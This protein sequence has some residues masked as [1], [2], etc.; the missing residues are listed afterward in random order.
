MT[1]SIEKTKKAVVLINVG[2]PDAPTV[3]AVRRYLAEFLWDE[4][5]IDLPKVFR[6]MLLH[7]IILPFRPK[8]SAQA[9][10]KIWKENGSP[11]LLHSRE[12]QQALQSLL[13]DRQV[14]LA[15]R[16]GK[17]S[18]AEAAE[19]LKRQEISDITVVPLYPQYASAT[20]GTSV[21]RA[22]KLWPTQGLRQVDSFYNNPGFIEACA[23]KVSSF[24]ADHVLFSYHGLP[25][26]QLR[27][28]CDKKC[29]QHACPR[30][31]ASNLHCYRAQCFA[32]SEAIAKAAGLSQTSTSFQSRIKGATWTGPF[33][34]E[35][36]VELAQQGVKRLAV[37]CP[38]FVADCL[39]SLEE[40]GERAAESFRRAGGEAF[41]L[42]PAVNA[43]PRFIHMLAEEIK[44]VAP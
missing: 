37:A 10:G 39:E 43:H 36:V 41:A 2:T 28:V 38:S 26:R 8:R 31:E 16:Y 1:V 18:M 6:W 27:P 15:M 29:H 35:V 23:E 12:Q 42:V 13:P 20:T 24:K 33:T 4:R 44:R 5:V 7:F 14:V 25:V 30:V 34:E 32:T 11:L 40:I 3:P 9:Y 19:N 22:Q 21:E 17:P